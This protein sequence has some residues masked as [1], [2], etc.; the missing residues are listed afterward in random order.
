MN[1]VGRN[2]KKFRFEK[3]LTQD[4]LA[5]RINVSRQTVSSW[6]TGRNEPDIESLQLLAGV[7]DVTVEEL[8][9][10]KR[11]AVDLCSAARSQTTFAN[12]NRRCAARISSLNSIEFA[13]LFV[14]SIM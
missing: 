1:A 3:G 13:S 4:E 6:E 2:L 11:N 9:Y 14:L 7:L 8:I 12:I 5:R 10:G